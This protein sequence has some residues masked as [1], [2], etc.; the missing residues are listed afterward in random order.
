MGAPK[1]NQFW[2]MRSKHGREKL[3]SSPELLWDAVSEYFQWCDDNPWT[4]RKAIQK[5]IPTKVKKGKKEEVENQQHVYQEITPTSRP[6]SLSGLCV[7]LN[8]STN[9]WREFRASCLR[10]DDKDFLEIISRVEEIIR[11]QQ[12]EGAC[13]GAFNSNIIARTLGLADKQEIDH[14]TNKK[15]F[16]GFE[17]LPFT[18]EAEKMKN[19]TEDKP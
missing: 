2:R 11:T 15:E 3:F 4:T 10:K 13:V 7:Y 19:E 9:W 16:K 12:F 17:F 18:A 5:T 8:A 6:Y 1:G 14:T